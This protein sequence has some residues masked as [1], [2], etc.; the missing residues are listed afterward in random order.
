MSQVLRKVCRIEY[1]AFTNNRYADPDLRRQ[2]TSCGWALV[3]YHE[4]RRQSAYRHI[5]DY[6]LTTVTDLVDLLGSI[7]CRGCDGMISWSFAT[8]NNE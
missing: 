7:D 1:S 8:T 2:H 5:A 6:G 3:E 4:G